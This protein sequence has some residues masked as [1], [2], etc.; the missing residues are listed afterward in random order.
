ML[1]IYW[2]SFD[3]PTDTWL[4]GGKLGFNRKTNQTQKLISWRSRENPATGFYNLQSGPNGANQYFVYRNN[5]EQI[6]SSGEWNEESKTFLLFSNNYSYISNVNESYFTYS[7]YNNSIIT[8]LVI[9]FTGRIQ[10]L[11]W[12]E[13]MQTWNLFWS[14]PKFCEAHGICGPFGNC[15]QQD[16]DQNCECLPG[17]VQLSPKDWNLQDFTGGCVRKTPLHCGSINCF[18]PLQTSKLPD[19]PKLFVGI[20]SRE[21]CKS[22]CEVTC[23]CIACTFVNNGCRYWDEDIINFKKFTSSGELIIF[24][25]KLAASEIRSTVP[26][27][28]GPSLYCSR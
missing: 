7:L 15:N 3:Y 22:S 1:Y 28:S 10:Q 25:L 14:E 21:E 9:D 4:R 26:L 5:S 6:W 24:Y 12:S 8:R 16:T 11:T 18:S 23:P 19:K 2:R 27:P 20:I 13:K 17:F